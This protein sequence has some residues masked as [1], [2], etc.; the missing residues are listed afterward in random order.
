MNETILIG[1]YDN[2]KIMFHTK[3]LLFDG[4]INFLKKILLL[5]K[6]IKKIIRLFKP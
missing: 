1:F 4:V 3:I 2:K 6:M 5:A